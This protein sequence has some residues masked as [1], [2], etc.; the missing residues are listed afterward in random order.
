M[1]EAELIKH[2]SALF[3]NYE[4]HFGSK[5]IVKVRDNGGKTTTM[6]F[7]PDTKELIQVQ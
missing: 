1:N 3:K 6:T 7:D 2:V 5:I 4:V